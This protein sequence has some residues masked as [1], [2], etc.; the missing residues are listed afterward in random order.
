MKSFFYREVQLFKI[1]FYLLIFPNLNKDNFFVNC[2]MGK[3]TYDDFNLLF[4]NNLNN[5]TYNNHTLKQLTEE[6][7]LTKQ[8]KNVSNIKRNN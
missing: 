4:A 5:I 7:N 3:K 2:S 1:H 8:D 6:I